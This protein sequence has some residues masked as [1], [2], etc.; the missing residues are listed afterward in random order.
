MCCAFNTY[1]TTLIHVTSGKFINIIIY[2][3]LFTILSYKRNIWWWYNKMFI[4][5]AFLNKDN[6]SFCIRFIN[7]IYSC[8]NCLICRDAINLLSI[9][10][11]ICRIYHFIIISQIYII[12]SFPGYTAIFSLYKQLN[13]ISSCWKWSICKCKCALYSHR[14]FIY[15]CSINL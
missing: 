3:C 10:S 14:L 6:N 12:K 9:C 4:I 7:W 8:L 5:I 11:I 13:I 1:C 15:N 2:S